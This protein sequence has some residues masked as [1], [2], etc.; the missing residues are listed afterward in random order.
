MG[1][2]NLNSNET[3]DE[4]VSWNDEAEIDFFG[5]SNNDNP[6]AKDLLFANPD[7]E[8]EAD[9]ADDT[10]PDTELEKTAE[11]TAEEAAE[12]AIKDNLFNLG[13]EEEEEEEEG[14]NK[15]DKPS[16]VG[17]S[18]LELFN[19]LR[20]RGLIEYE[21]EEGA[22]P[23]T[24]ERAAEL[25]EDLYE[26]GLESK[27]GEKLQALPQIVQ[28]LV[29][30]TMKGGSEIS[31]LQELAKRSTA[32][33]AITKDMDLDDE[34]NA[35]LVMRQKLR[36]E[37]NDDEYINA[38][39][40]FLK[41][42]GKLVPLGKKAHVDIL[43]KDKEFLDNKVQE[44]HKASELRKQKQ[45]EFRTTIV[46]ELAA[47]NDLNGYPVDAKSKRELPDYMTRESVVL[48][49][50]NKIT[51]YQLALHKILQDPKKNLILA[52]LVRNDLDLSPLTRLGKTEQ[53]KKV[54]E[55]VRRNANNS[56]GSQP[57]ARTIKTLADWFEE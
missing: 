4:K 33:T 52:E 26:D 34:K 41:Q 39:I 51:P 13:D 32:T 16:T 42:S 1:K 15:K 57:K 25:V 53:T 8:E 2:T 12:K 28:D 36:N 9:E 48:E 37:G 43:A 24:D 7:K 35:E 46:S 27:I 22:E 44:A 21:E 38:N 30:Y 17:K 23:L 40:D 20:E 31:F 11:E 55:N 3:A 5:V 50:G 14:A 19:Q 18:N 47:A 45:R 54:Q 49:N 29:K 6:D 10:K 56:G